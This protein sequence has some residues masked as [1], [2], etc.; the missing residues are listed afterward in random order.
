MLGYLRLLIGLVL[1]MNKYK[2]VFDIKY[3]AGTRLISVPEGVS[4]VTDEDAPRGRLIGYTDELRPGL[5]PYIAQ[6]DSAESQYEPVFSKV[7]PLYKFHGLLTPREHRAIV[8]RI[9]GVDMFS[10]PDDELLRYWSIINAVNEV[11]VD[12]PMFV[13]CMGYLASVKALTV[14]RVAEIRQGIAV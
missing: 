4:G 14:E 6:N 3:K 9:D 13:E 8:S 2:V 7:M 11:N 12:H 1:T 5:V 10:T